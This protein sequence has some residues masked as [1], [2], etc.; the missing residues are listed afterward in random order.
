MNRR[1][2]FKR[3]GM[4]AVLPLAA[5]VVKIAPEED[6]SDYKYTDVRQGKTTYEYAAYGNS[7]TISGSTNGYD[8]LLR[9]IEET[10]IRQRERYFANMLNSAFIK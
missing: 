3:L 2:F 5:R 9:D 7:I 4:L 8:R 10:R 1:T 6:I